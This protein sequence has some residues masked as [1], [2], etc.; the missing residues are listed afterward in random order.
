MYS[1]RWLI[2]LIAALSGGAPLADTTTPDDPR[3]Q[4][5]R[6]LVMTSGCNDCHTPDYM[7]KDGEVAEPAWLSGSAVGFQGPWGTTYPVNLRLYMQSISESRW[8]QRA[9]Q[10]MRPPMPW[11][12]LKAMTDT[13][14]GAIYHYVRALGPVGQPAP[15]AVPAGVA[16]TT[17]YFDFTPKNLPAQANQ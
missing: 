10:P 7:E 14:L 3:V 9:R 8:L 15:G 16:V 13:D 4:R 17:P 5:G 12:N 2:T 6:Y 11:F 1:R